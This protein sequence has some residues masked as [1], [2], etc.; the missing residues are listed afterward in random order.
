M[1]HEP[2]AALL[3]PGPEGPP[4]AV[5]S[6]AAR[7]LLDLPP[8]SPAAAVTPAWLAAH[9]RPAAVRLAAIVSRYGGAVLADAPGLGKSYVAM[10]VALMC[11][12]SFTLVVPAVLVSQWG[13]LCR[14]FDVTPE[15]RT[16]EGLSRPFIGQKPS[17]RSSFR[18]FMSRR[19]PRCPLIIVDEAHH[20]R[21][22]ATR[23]YR[24]LAEL[25]MGARVLL[26]T[27][28]PVH[29]RIGDLVH[30]LRLFMRDDALA[31]LGVPSL[32][33][34]AAGES[35]TELPGAL[36]HIV[37]ARS[38]SRAPTIVLPKRARGKSIRVGP[39]PD[40]RLAEMVSKIA[41]CNPG[42]AGALVRMVLLTRL[43][44]SLPAFRESLSR[45][46]AFADFSD[47]AKHSGRALTRHDFQ[48]F[49]PR[50]EEPDL[51]L[52]LLPLLLPQGNGQ[53]PGDRL[54]FPRL[55]DL[56][57]GAPDPKAGRLDQLLSR[58]LAKTIVFT[59]SRATARYL[60]RTLQTR[61][62]VAA[63]MGAR[64]LLPSGPIPVPEILAAFAPM[65]TGVPSPQARLAMDVLIATDLA[66]EGLNLQDA[67]RV[68]H[69]DLPWT[70]ARLAQRVG[71]I[72]RIGSAHPRIQVVTFLPPPSLAHAIGFETR[73]LAK[74]RVGRRAGLF[75]WCDRLQVLVQDDEAALCAVSGDEE[76]TL[77]V[78]SVGGLA[79]ALVVRKNGLTA[80][81]RIA[82]A[83]LE[84]A[85][86][87][88]AIPHDGEMLRAAIC[89]AAPAIRQRLDQLVSARWRAGDRDQLSRRLIPMVVREA[90]RA[91]REGNAP[92]VAMLDALVERLGSGMTAGEELSLAAL[93][94]SP[95]PLTV[96][97]LC[98]WSR[99]L[100]T[101]DCR[102]VAPDIRLT[103]AIVVRPMWRG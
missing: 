45:Q 67:S 57:S 71:R 101:L 51:Q 98:D 35:W 60:L 49:F 29:N 85:V 1:I 8:V 33:R 73:L 13:Q 4:P 34:A 6:R 92:R 3:T 61:H 11:E 76:A 50:G 42:P 83:L 36:A 63:V 48:R 7:A 99:G 88:P 31:G 78:F 52:A 20:Y 81:P 91:A 15:I 66:S 10:A 90:R 72:D 59:S 12:D 38:R 26:V 54:A 64:G 40:Q 94:E 84:Q 96:D 37:V 53:A 14:R 30:L 24:A 46:E 55:K 65:A 68:I 102:T 58:H 22:P 47:E 62:R 27:A 82:C 103:A 56:A 21:N 2:L 74:A 16:H 25:T 44:S 41:T 89:R 80:D 100:P 43:A 39:A 19:Q 28:T 79:E 86:T 97:S 75:D 32:K 77:L 18:D 17:P 69:Y 95:A 5:A 9:Q 87:A 23:R 93:A 70:A